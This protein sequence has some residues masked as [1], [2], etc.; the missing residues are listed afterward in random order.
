M[1]AYRR[2]AE[3]I[4]IN[5]VSVLFVFLL[6]GGILQGRTDGVVAERGHTFFA[7]GM[8]KRIE[9]CA[10][11]IDPKRFGHGKR[12]EIRPIGCGESAVGKISAQKH[13]DD[14]NDECVDQYGEQSADRNAQ[15]VIAE[16]FTHSPSSDSG[17]QSRQGSDEHVVYPER[18]SDIAQHT[19]DVQSGDRFREKQGKDRE[20]FGG[21]DL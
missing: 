19:A 9:W 4:Q 11:C 16:D 6:Y 10:E 1:K 20:R 7:H 15:N 21:T 14:G 17:Y 13:D 5:S 8:N 3:R 18:G 12:A 2:K